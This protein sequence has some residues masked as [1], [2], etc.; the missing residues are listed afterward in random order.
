MLPVRADLSEHMK[1]RRRSE[2][3]RPT[4]KQLTA[5][6]HWELSY[7]EAGHAVERA[8]LGYEVSELYFDYDTG[9]AAVVHFVEDDTDQEHEIMCIL[10]GSVA[11]AMFVKTKW[12]VRKM[13]FGSRA[14]SGDSSNDLDEAYEAARSL[15]GFTSEE[16]SDDFYRDGM[17][18][19][20]HILPEYADRTAFHLK[21]NWHHVEAVAEAL[22]RNGYL[23]QKDF[24]SV[25]RES[26]L[27]AALTETETERN[28]VKSSQSGPTRVAA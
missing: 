12:S 10:A 8:L 7:H 18:I 24:Y 28:A 20:K 15:K 27:K 21:M 22:N 14:M 16:K 25:L 6:E 3:S 5:R 1:A 19:E 9:H 26:A 2:M 4:R 11:Q 17:L 23:T 13:C